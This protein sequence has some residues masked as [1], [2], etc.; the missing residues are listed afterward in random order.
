M[1]H[2][3]AVVAILLTCLSKLNKNNKIIIC[4]ILH[5]NLSL[6]LLIWEKV[7]PILLLWKCCI[8]ADKKIYLQI[9]KKATMKTQHQFIILSRWG[10][11]AFLYLPVCWCQRYKIEIILWRKTFLDSSFLK[12]LHH[13]I[14]AWEYRTNISSMKPT[15]T[16]W[17]SYETKGITRTA[18]TE[19][20]HRSNTAA[21]DNNNR[22]FFMST[23]KTW[24]TL[25]QQPP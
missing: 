21:F 6:F 18:S 19:R 13:T 11:S 16:W 7:K 14:P 3:F 22:I 12:L 24:F 23:L 20:A 5:K 8:H 17:G 25:E 15:L 2:Q 10:T 9:Y 4:K 1:W